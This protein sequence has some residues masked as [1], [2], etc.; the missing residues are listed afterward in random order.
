MRDIVTTVLELVGGALIVGGV[1]AFSIP[2]AAIVA[3][4]LLVTVSWR[5]S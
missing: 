1:A 3:G 5:A 2:V 4:G